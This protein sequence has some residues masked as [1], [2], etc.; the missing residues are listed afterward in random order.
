MSSWKPL[1]SLVTH[2]RLVHHNY[3]DMRTLKH[4]FVSTYITV[5]F[6]DMRAARIDGS[7]IRVSCQLGFTMVRRWLVVVSDRAAATAGAS[8]KHMCSQIM[9]TASLGPY[10]R[11]HRSPPVKQQCW[12]MN[13]KTRIKPT[14]CNS[15]LT[16]TCKWPKS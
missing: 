7:T 16:H 12:G 10:V 9:L 1:F 4:K 3:I 13:I 2:E 15:C 11:L 8:T 14:S 5:R 6:Q